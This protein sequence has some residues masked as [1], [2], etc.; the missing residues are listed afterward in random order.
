MDKLDGWIRENPLPALLIVG[1]LAAMGWQQYRY[2]QLGKELSK[3]TACSK[4]P[5][6][7]DRD[8]EFG[9]YAVDNAVQ[10][11]TGRWFFQGKECKAAGCSE[12]IA[13][14]RWAERMGATKTGACSSG[15][16]EFK[17]GCM[18]F[19]SI[20]D[21]RQPDEYEAEPISTRSGG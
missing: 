17:D 9:S 11:V 7:Q 1:L 10:S 12:V 21:D 3:A 16:E 19:V 15:S 8:A 4:S 6:C 2:W 20:Y 14:Y 13:G 5:V 18:S